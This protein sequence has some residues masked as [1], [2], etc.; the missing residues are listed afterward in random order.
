MFCVVNMLV[1][2]RQLVL[3]VAR[4]HG[5]RALEVLVAAVLLLVSVHLRVDRL[6]RKHLNNQEEV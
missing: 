4:V 5:V 6:S 1:V 2:R 3:V